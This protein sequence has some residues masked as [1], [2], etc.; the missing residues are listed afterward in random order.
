MIRSF[1]YTLLLFLTSQLVS[2]NS[3]RDEFNDHTKSTEIS[4]SFSADKALLSRSSETRSAN[5]LIYQYD[6]LFDINSIKVLVIAAQSGQFIDTVKDISVVQLSNGDY[7]LNGKVTSVE[8]NFKIVMLVNCKPLDM[9]YNS[10]FYLYD[11]AEYNPF[12]DTKKA[13]PL[14]GELVSQV[15]LQPGKATFIGTVSMHRAMAKVEVALSGQSHG[16]ELTEVT[17]NYYND[18]G[19][20]VPNQNIDDPRIPGSVIVSSNAAFYKADNT[21]FIIYLP[22]Y[23]NNGAKKLS[24]KIKLKD[25]NGTIIERDLLVGEYQQSVF[26]TSSHLVRNHHYKYNLNIQPTRSNGFYFD[27]NTEESLLN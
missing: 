15:T 18:R 12:S 21:K 20:F 6:V 9:Y 24:M 23:I 5:D 22:E 25:A 3:V 27:I 14:W 8:D 4:F 17:M 19:S 7:L 10:D 2:C 11:P 13:I 26:M 1:L 16:Y